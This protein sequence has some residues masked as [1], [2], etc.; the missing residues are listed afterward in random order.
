MKL[1][2]AMM[3]TCITAA[4]TP[5]MDHV[6]MVI[7]GVPAMASSIKSDTRHISVS[8]E[9]NKSEVL[10]PLAGALDNISIAGIVTRLRLFSVNLN[11]G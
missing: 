11:S 9:S 3:T 6:P 1:K 8:N 7:F 4:S 10:I 5:V 2:T